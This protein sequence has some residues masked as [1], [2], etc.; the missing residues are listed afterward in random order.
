MSPE[1]GEIRTRQ[2]LPKSRKHKVY[3]LEREMG[4]SSMLAQRGHS[5]RARAAR[6]AMQQDA[7][8]AME[9]RRRRS[10]AKRD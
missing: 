4:E 7:A 3:A 10:P 1:G 6:R 5:K 9:L 2:Q 8:E